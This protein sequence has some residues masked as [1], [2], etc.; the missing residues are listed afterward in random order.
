MSSKWVTTR[1]VRVRAPGPPLIVRSI[2]AVQGLGAHPFSTWVKKVP[3]QKSKERT[4]SKM[5]SSPLLGKGVRQAKDK[6]CDARPVMWLRDLLVPAFSSAR[7]ATYSYKSDWRDRQVITSLRE[8]GQQLLEVLL[9]HR[10]NVHVR[11]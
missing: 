5:F 1:S 7:V 6:E 3:I 8:C 11:R 2:I 9:Q 10:A 4:A